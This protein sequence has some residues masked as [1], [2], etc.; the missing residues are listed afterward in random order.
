VTT[1]AA[2]NI[3]TDSATLNGNLTALGSAS[4]VAVSFEWGT[5]TSYGNTIDG[6]PSSR[7]ST[8]TFTAGLT[9]L[10]S[11]TYHYRAKAAGDGTDYG[12]DQEFT[13]GSSGGDNRLEITIDHTK[14]TSDLTQFPV[15]L[16]LS[17]DC[18]TNDADMSAVFTELGADWQKLRVT[19][20]SDTDL[21]VEVES[22]DAIN[23]EA[24]LWVSRPGWT[25]SSTTDTILYLYYDN[26]QPDN[27]AYVGQTGSTPGQSVWDSNYKAVYHMN[28]ATSTTIADSK[29]SHTGTK[30]GAVESAGQ[31]G[32]A[33]YFDGTNDKINLGN[34]TDWNLA[35][36][37]STFEMSFNAS[38]T[39]GTG[40][41][42]RLWERFMGG[43]P[44][45]GYF[46]AILQSGGNFYFSYGASSNAI[47]IMSPS[48]CADDTYRIIAI[49]V[50]QSTQYGRF[51]MDG[52]YVSQNLFNTLLDY[53][54]NLYVGGGYNYF[55][56]LIDEFRISNTNRPDAWIAATNYT[57]RDNL[58]SLTIES[59]PSQSETLYQ[60]QYTWDPAGNLDLRD[61]FNLQTSTWE[62]EDFT[63]DFL[64]RLTVVSSA[65]YSKTYTNNA[66]GNLTLKDGNTLN[67]PTNGVRPHAVSAMGSTNY[68]YDA[69]GNMTTR[70]TQTLTWD[71][72]NRLSTVT[73][74]A[75]FV[76]DGDGN[77][78]KKTEGGETILYVNQ[79]YEKNLTTREVTT[80]YY[81]GGKL[82]AQNK[83]LDTTDT[84]RYIQQDSLGSTSMMAD[85]SGQ[86]VGT[87]KYFPYGECRNSLENIPTDRLFTGQRLDS[88]GLYY[89]NARY[90][91]ANIGRFI[92]ADPVVPNFIDP[93]SYNRYSYCV[94]NPLKYSDPTGN[95]PVQ[96]PPEPRRPDEPPPEPPVNPNPDPSEPELPI[97]PKNAETNPL[98]LYPPIVAVVPEVIVIA[99]IVIIVG[100][101]LTFNYEYN[102][103]VAASDKP[104]VEKLILMG[105]SPEAVSFYMAKRGSMTAGEIIGNEKKGSINREFPNQWRDKTYNEITKAA[106]SGDKTAQ[107]AKKL[108]DDGR[109]D[110]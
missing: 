83:H 107:K 96:R 13:I 110:K 6:T 65:A 78:V 24:W 89:Y 60:T 27:T 15:L 79:F 49:Q 68:A 94:N 86:A 20:A 22:W 87:I 46:G 25:V 32:K 33:Q 93:Q 51:Y 19:D 18:G 4:S 103:E 43:S 35:G 62:N 101:T 11:G 70:G 57:L 77:R 90:Y 95:I 50:N 40:S 8:G 7:S 108:L 34:S 1:N 84:L 82:I 5:T 69:N 75:S 99:G 63:Y 10:T 92:S 41:Y 2:S 47:D 14:V 9:D 30:S 104:I 105:Y 28:D 36:S 74:G 106:K 56:G 17:G 85:A 76:Y 72:E 48:S 53:N 97:A 16:H 61:T 81:L 38:S 52:N 37:N 39:L 42:T 31:S 80:Y 54:G 109:F 26:T 91:D 98:Y 66:I 44:N 12:E 102:Q 3:D 45:R 100:G 88:T 71:V 59:G 73:G 29:G 23:Y 21:Y 55:H 64:D 58:V 67:Y